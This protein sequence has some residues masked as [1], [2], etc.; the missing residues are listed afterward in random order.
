MTHNVEYNRSSAT[1]AQKEETKANIESGNFK[2]KKKVNKRQTTIDQDTV[3]KALD[4]KER[5]I[6]SLKFS[7]DRMKEAKVNGETLT[8]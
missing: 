5:Q 4:L 7:A 3:K 2:P 1:E 6:R 8:F